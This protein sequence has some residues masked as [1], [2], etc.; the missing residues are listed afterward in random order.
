MNILENIINHEIME[1]VIG[2]RK[3]D[4]YI[5]GTGRRFFIKAVCKTSGRYSCINNPNAIISELKITQNDFKYY[6][7]MW[8]TKNA[9][10]F[11]RKIVSFLSDKFSLEYVEDKLDEDRLYGEWENKIKIN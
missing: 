9:Y 4:F 1:K 10:N 3:Y 6:D 11:Y 8:T 2:G 5:V 7:S